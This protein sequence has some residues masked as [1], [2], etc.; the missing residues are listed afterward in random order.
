VFATIARPRKRMNQAAM[1]EALILNRPANYDP[2]TIVVV[3]GP[4]PNE[5]IEQF[6]GSCLAR[7]VIVVEADEETYKV[8]KEHLPRERHVGMKSVSLVHDSIYEVL[9]R[10]ESV[11]GVDFDLFYGG[12]SKHIIP[13]AGSLRNLLKNNKAKSFWIRFTNGLRG[14][15]HDQ[16]H[17]DIETIIALA[18]GDLDY[19][20]VG[21]SD[22]TYKDTM[23]MHSWQCYFVRK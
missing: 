14:V 2:D 6:V 12:L 10:T 8:A 18:M 4:R 1:T 21:A 22:S 19:E 5:E 17:K 9:K 11:S 16:T 15:G 23:A 20:I 13:L 7:N 3:G